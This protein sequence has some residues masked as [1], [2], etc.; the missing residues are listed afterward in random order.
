[1]LTNRLLRPYLYINIVSI[2]T[3]KGGFCLQNCHDSFKRVVIEF[4]I[5]IEGNNFLLKKGLSRN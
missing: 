2:E 4:T 3:Y 5:F 1:M